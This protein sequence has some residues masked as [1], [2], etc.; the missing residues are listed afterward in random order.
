MSSPRGS[1]R[2][3][4]ADV[5]LARG[6]PRGELIQVQLQREQLPPDDERQAMLAER[7]VLLSRP[8]EQ[9]WRDRIPDRVINLEF[10]RGFVYGATLNAAA[11]GDGVPAL[12]DSEPL[13]HLR[14]VDLSPDD[15]PRLAMAPWLKRLAGL[16][17][18]HLQQLDRRRALNFEDVIRLLDTDGLRG[19]KRLGLS[20]HRIEDMGAMVLARNLP[21]AAPKLL[22]LQVARDE[23]TPV[24]VGTL[25]ETAWFQR[26][27][28][29]DLGYNKLG[30]G[31]ADLI[32]ACVS[33]G[34][35]RELDLADNLLGDEGAR[36]IANAPAL[37]GLVSLGLYQNH[38]GSYGANALLDSPYLRRVRKLNLGKNRMGA[39]AARRLAER[40]A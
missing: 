11:L 18:N 5:L 1:P 2:L 35:L 8:L 22:E 4:Y 6:D 21:A 37:M 15:V 14:L 24:G 28:S 39:V 23:L 27:N 7:E 10:R 3:V 38:I 13:Q 34:R 12:F 30:A 26:L 20:G 31:G 16:E 32:G 36:S 9:A 29:I 40:T 33:P 17:L 25:A 19:L